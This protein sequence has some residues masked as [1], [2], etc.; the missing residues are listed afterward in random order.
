M[1]LCVHFYGESMPFILDMAT[2]DEVLCAISKCK[3]MFDIDNR[4][5][6]VESDRI[7]LHA[8]KETIRRKRESGLYCWN[9]KVILTNHS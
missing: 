2:E 5:Y 7:I 6:I 9:D 8:R 1:F 4:N 3:E